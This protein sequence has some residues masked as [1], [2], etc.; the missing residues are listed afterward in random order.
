MS[1]PCWE[2]THLKCLI[3]QQKFPCPCCVLARISVSFQVFSYIWYLIIEFCWSRPVS[4][5]EG[6]MKSAGRNKGCQI[7]PSLCNNC[8]AAFASCQLWYKVRSLRLCIRRRSS[9]SLNL[10]LSYLWNLT[11]VT[12]LWLSFFLCRIGI[13]SMKINE[14]FHIS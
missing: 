9:I 2:L 13:M 14:I 1:F 11:Q 5:A 8:V 7:E 6:Q 10:L 4:V 3:G 12:K